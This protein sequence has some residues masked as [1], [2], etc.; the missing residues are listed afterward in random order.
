MVKRGYSIHLLKKGIFKED[1]LKNNLIDQKRTI[2][3]VDVISF[4]KKNYPRLSFMGI[5]ELRKIR[6]Q[7]VHKGTDVDPKKRVYFIDSID[8]LNALYLTEN[9]RHKKFL[10]EIIDSKQEI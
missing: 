2:D 10:K 8:C 7:I 6:N 4:F 3:L 1:E 9:I 5:E